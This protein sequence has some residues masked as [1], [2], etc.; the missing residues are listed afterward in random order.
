[1]GPRCLQKDKEVILVFGFFLLEK[2]QTI[3]LRGPDGMDGGGSVDLVNGGAP[4][5]SS[6]CVIW[7]T[8]SS[9]APLG[10]WSTR[11]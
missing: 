6:A 7:S 4:N 3:Q 8:W 9:C 5:L 10:S 1:M 2:I 11:R